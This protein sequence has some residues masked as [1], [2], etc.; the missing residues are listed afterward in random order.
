MSAVFTLAFLVMLVGV[1]IYLLI[2]PARYPL[3]GARILHVADVMFCIG[4]FVL[5]FCGCWGQHTVASLFV[6]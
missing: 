6:K 4:L 3:R 2:D 1:L 5:L